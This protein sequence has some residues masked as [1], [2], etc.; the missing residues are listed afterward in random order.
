MYYT[1]PALFGGQHVVDH[2]VDAI[3]YTFD[4]PRSSLNVVRGCCSTCVI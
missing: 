1:D 2:Y 3:A 4:V